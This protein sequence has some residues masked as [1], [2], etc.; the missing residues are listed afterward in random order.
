MLSV[1]T[2]QPNQ[3][4]LDHYRLKKLMTGTLHRTK[5]DSPKTFTQGF[6]VNA[7]LWLIFF[8]LGVV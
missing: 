2:R 5:N 4:T 6:G 3:M 1:K 8:I 7:F